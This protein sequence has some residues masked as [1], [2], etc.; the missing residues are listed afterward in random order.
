MNNRPFPICS[1]L[2]SMFLQPVMPV[3]T[4]TVMAF[5]VVQ[6]SSAIAQ[7]GPPYTALELALTSNKIRKSCPSEAMLEGVKLEGSA[8][9]L[10]ETDADGTPIRVSVLVS[11][12]QP[13]LDSYGMKHLFCQTFVNKRGLSFRQNM[14]FSEENGRSESPDK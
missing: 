7:A 4:A 5:L 9:Y 11:T 3:V 13:A 6:P 14:S 2:M 10:V 8:V 1:C 12:G